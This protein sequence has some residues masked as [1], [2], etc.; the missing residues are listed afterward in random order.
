VPAVM[1]FEVE[2]KACINLLNSSWKLE[3]VINMVPGF[4]NFQ[5]RSMQK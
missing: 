1:A 2:P 5:I 3:G 4:G